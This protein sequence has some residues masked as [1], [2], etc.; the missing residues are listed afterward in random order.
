MEICSQLRA[1]MPTV[2]RVCPLPQPSTLNPEPNPCGGISLIKNTHLLVPY[3]RTIWGHLVILG[4]G[5][6]SYERGRAIAVNVGRVWSWG[7]EV[8]EAFTIL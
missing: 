3:S 5:V 8:F 2:W 4:G 7:L 1:Q 6:V